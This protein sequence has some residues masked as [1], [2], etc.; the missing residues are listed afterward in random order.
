MYICLWFSTLSVANVMLLKMYSSLCYCLTPQNL[1]S[2]V[3]HINHYGKC[4]M[5]DLVIINCQAYFL[6]ISIRLFI[7]LP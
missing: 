4:K 2:L 6:H 3:H 5:V 7:N 1:K